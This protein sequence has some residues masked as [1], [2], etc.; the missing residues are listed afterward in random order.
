MNQ[1]P[2]LFLKQRMWLFRVFKRTID[3]V[4]SIILLLVFSPIIFITAILIKLTSKGPIFF[5]Q[6]RV[7]ENSQ[8]FVMYK[9]R[10]MFT[11]DNDK[12]LREE[13]PNLWKKYKENGWK[14]PMKEDPRITPIGRVLRSLTIDEFPQLFFNVLPGQMSLIGP[15]AYREEELQEYEQKYPHTC[16]Y[17]NDIRS[18]KPGITGP[19]QTSGRNEIPFEQRAKLDSEY[20]RNRSFIREVVILF[21][22]PMAMISR[23]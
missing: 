20:I 9:F 17:I 4:G 2:K 11:G 7:G 13:Y 22:T 16:G 12:R 14:L 23:W 5:T 19:W 3:I 1:K 8:P 21:K 10:T 18:V 6:K 15:R